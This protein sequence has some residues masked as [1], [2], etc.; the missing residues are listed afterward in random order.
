MFS[1]SKTRALSLFL[2]VMLLLIPIAGAVSNADNIKAANL[3][4]APKTSTT[5]TDLFSELSAKFELYNEN[6]NKVPAVVKRLVASE[7]IA[8][9]IQLDNGK[10][11]Y[12]TLQMKG[13]KVGDFY[14][15]DTPEDPNSKFGPSIT[16]ETDEKTIRQVLDSKDPLEETIDCMNNE[17]IKVETEGFFRKTALWTLKQF[18]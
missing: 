17:S 2:L 8:G 1:H 12:V 9:K 7:E 15:Y 16:V 6:F 13:A 5:E 18:N 11:L 4:K 10:M 14:K 3:Y